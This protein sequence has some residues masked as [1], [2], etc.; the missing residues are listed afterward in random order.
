MGLGRATWAL[1]LA[2]AAHSCGA[3]AGAAQSTRTAET[4][5]VLRPPAC[6]NDTQYNSH[7]QG[8]TYLEQAPRDA[9]S[10]ESCGELCDA[11]AGCRCFTWNGPRRHCWLLSACGS[12]VAG[13]AVAGFVSGPAGC[14]PSGGAPAATAPAAGQAPPATRSSAGSWWRQQAGGSAA[15]DATG[16]PEEIAS[17][18]RLDTSRAAP[19]MR[20]VRGPHWAWGEQDGGAGGE[21][22]LTR[23]MNECAGGWWWKVKWDNGKRNIYRTGC[24]GKD[25]LRPARCSSSPRAKPRV[26]KYDDIFSPAG[27]E[28]AHNRW[29]CRNGGSVRVGRSCGF[30]RGG[31]I[32]ENATCIGPGQWSSVAPACMPSADADLPLCA[33]DDLTVPQGA[34]P[35][36][37]LP[38]CL[39]GGSVPAGGHCIFLGAGL[40][41][42]LASCGPD[43]RWAN[44]APRCRQA[45]PLPEAAGLPSCSFGELIPPA[46]AV[47]GGSEGCEPFG[48]VPHGGQ[49]RFTRSGFRCAAARCDAGR[50]FPQ[51]PLCSS[52]GCSFAALAL[53]PGVTARGGGCAGGE[54]VAPGG[55]CSLTL[56][57]GG[58]ASSRDCGYAVCSHAG[59]WQV[60]ADRCRHAAAGS[61]YSLPEQELRST[62]AAVAAA[63]AAESCLRDSDF[64]AGLAVTR[65]P[66]WG[67]G[68][69]DGGPGKVGVVIAR[70]EECPGGHWWQVM[71]TPS[72]VTN[73]YRVGCQGKTD[74]CPASSGSGGGRGAAPGRGAGGRGRR[75]GR[76]GGRGGG[77]AAVAPAALFRCELGVAHSAADSAVVRRVPS[78]ERC[79]ELC[80]ALSGCR[81][82]QWHRQGSGGVE[83]GRCKLKGAEGA[84][85]QGRYRDRDATLCVRQNAPGAAAEGGSPDGLPPQHDWPCHKSSAEA[86]AAVSALFNVSGVPTPR[87]C[88]AHCAALPDCAAAAHDPAA[89]TCLVLPAQPPAEPT[90]GPTLTV[91]VRADGANSDR[92]RPAAQYQCGRDRRFEG[93][94][95]FHFADVTDEAVCQGYCDRVPECIGVVLDGHSCA[96]KAFLTAPSE[97][98]PGLGYVACIRIGSAEAAAGGAASDFECAS[99][100]RFS[101]QPLLSAAG[102]SNQTGCNALCRGLPDCS[103]TAFS[104]GGGC[105]LLRGGGELEAPAGPFVEGEVG[106]RHSRRAAAQQAPAPAIA[107]PEDEK[108]G[109]AAEREAQPLDEAPQFASVQEES[110]YY[111]DA[112]WTQLTLPDSRE[113]WIDD[114]RGT[115]SLSRPLGAGFS[116]RRD[117]YWAGGDLFRLIDVKTV[118][119][120]EATCR[121]VP[122]CAA[123][124]HRGACPRGSQTPLAHTPD[125]AKCH[126]CDI[127]GY[128]EGDLVQDP[129]WRLSTAC[130][131][132]GESQPAPSKGADVLLCIP[133]DCS[134]PGWDAENVLGYAQRVAQ[135]VAQDTGGVA[136]APELLC[137]TAE[138]CAP[139][140]PAQGAAAEPRRGKALSLTPRQ[141]CTDG[142][143]AEV[144]VTV[145]LPN[146]TGSDGDVQEVVEGAVRDAVANT[147]GDVPVTGTG[148]EVGPSQSPDVTGDC[149]VDKQGPADDLVATQRGVRTLSECRGL[150]S[151]MPQCAALSHQ[152]DLCQLY[153]SAE[154][155]ADAAGWTTC[156]ADPSL[157]TPPK[158]NLAVSLAFYLPLSP[159]EFEAMQGLLID[160]VTD[161]L[162]ARLPPGAQPVDTGA[163]SVRANMLAGSSAAGR[164]KGHAL[165]VS[166]VQ[167][168]L[169]L[170][171]GL[172]AGLTAGSLQRA[173]S[174]AAVHLTRVYKPRRYSCSDEYAL[175]GGRLLRLLG[176]EGA[177][178]CMQH[179]T[180]TTA[181]AALLYF[182]NGTCEL[183][184]ADFRQV[185][186][187]GGAVACERDLSEPPAAPTYQC[188]DDAAYVGGDLSALGGVESE[189]TCRAL[190]SDSASD[191]DLYVYRAADSSCLLKASGEAAAVSGSPELSGRAC[192]AAR[193]SSGGYLCAAGA[194]SA[195]AELFAVG[196]IPAPAGCE[197]LCGAVPRCTGFTHR[198]A[199][200]TCT[201]QAGAGTLQPQRGAGSTGCARSGAAGQGPAAAD[202]FNCQAHWAFEGSPL[203]VVENASRADDCLRSCGGVP[204]CA[205][206]TY[207]ESRCLLYPKGAES[208]PAASAVACTRSSDPAAE[209]ERAA[210]A[211]R[212]GA[213]SFTG[214]EL[215]QI[216][217][218]ATP[219]DCRAHCGAV[220]ECIV[221]EHSAAA[222]T[223]RSSSAVRAAQPAAGATA[224]VRPDGGSPAPAA[225]AG[226]V[227]YQ[228]SENTAYQGA[229]LAEVGAVHGAEDCQRHCSLLPDCALAEYRPQS[230]DGGLCRLAAAG[231][232]SARPTAAASVLCTKHADAAAEAARFDGGDAVWACGEGD[233]GG[234]DELFLLEGV[235]SA[236]QCS[237]Q[238]EQAAAC[239]SFTFRRLQGSC[240]LRPAAAAPEAP[241]PPEATTVSCSRTA[242]GAG[243]PPCSCAETW[244][245]PRDGGQCGS[246]QRGC[247][248]QACDGS[249]Q[250]W[251]MVSEPGCAA[252]QH[253]G[254]A[255]C[256][257]GTPAAAPG[258]ASRR[259]AMPQGIAD[260]GG[261]APERHFR[262]LT[263]SFEK[264][265]GDPGGI[266]V[267]SD[268]TVAAVAPGCAAEAGGLRY[269]MLITT[270]NGESVPTAGLAAAI[271]AAAGTVVLAV[272]QEICAPEVSYF[273]F[274]HQFHIPHLTTDVFRGAAQPDLGDSEPG[275]GGLWLHTRVR[276]RLNSILAPGVAQWMAVHNAVAEELG[277]PDAGVFGERLNPVL[278][279]LGLGA[280]D[281]GSVAPLQAVAFHTRAKKA[282]LRLL[283]TFGGELPSG[284]DGGA[285]AAALATLLGVDLERVQT[286]ELRRCN[287]SGRIDSTPDRCA[288]TYRCN[289][290]S[291]VAGCLGEDGIPVEDRVDMLLRGVLLPASASPTSRRA[292]AVAADDLSGAMDNRLA[293]ADSVSDVHYSG[294]RR[295]LLQSQGGAGGHHHDPGA[296][297]EAGSRQKDTDSL[298]VGGDQGQAGDPDRDHTAD[299]TNI[300]V[301]DLTGESDRHPHD[302]ESH[303]GPALYS[304]WEG[305]VLLDVDPGLSGAARVAKL[306]EAAQTARE[307][308]QW[309]IWKMSH[310]HAVGAGFGG[311]RFELLEQADVT[312]VV[313]GC[314]DCS[315]IAPTPVSAPTPP[316]EQP[317]ADAASE[318]APGSRRLLQLQATSSSSSSSS[319]S[320]SEGASGSAAASPAASPLRR[321]ERLRAAERA[322][323]L[324]L[325]TPRRGRALN[326][327][328]EGACSLGALGDFY[329]LMSNSYNVAPHFFPQQWA[330]KLKDGAQ[331]LTGVTLQECVS[332]CSDLP[333]TVCAG[334]SRRSI[335]SNTDIQ[336]GDC[337]LKR[338]LKPFVG[339]QASFDDWSTYAVR[340]PTER[341][342]CSWAVL[343]DVALHAAEEYRSAQPLP[344]EDACKRLC[345]LVGD[346]EG[347]SFAAVTQTCYLAHEGEARAADHPGF[348]SFL[349]ASSSVAVAASG[350]QTCAGAGTACVTDG[351]STCFEAPGSYRCGCRPGF[352][353]VR[354]L[355]NVEGCTCADPLAAKVCAAVTPPP[356]VTTC[357]EQGASGVCFGGPGAGSQCVGGEADW[358]CA[359]SDGFHCVGNCDEPR[360]K[361]SCAKDSC[362]DILLGPNVAGPLR[363]L[364]SDLAAAESPSASCLQTALAAADACRPCDVFN[365]HLRDCSLTGLTVSQK[366]VVDQAASVC[367]P[368]AAVTLLGAWQQALA[369]TLH[370]LADSAGSSCS[371]AAD[372]IE[373]IDGAAA[374]AADPAR[375]WT[376]VS[377]TSVPVQ[378]RKSH[379]LSLRLRNTNIAA[380]VGE[381]DDGISADGLQQIREQL[382]DYLEVPDVTVDRLC[383]YRPDTQE[384]QGCFDDAG[385][386]VAAHSA[387]VDEAAAATAAVGGEA[388]Q[389][390]QVVVCESPPGP[391]WGAQAEGPAVGHYAVR[392][393]AGLSVRVHGAFYGRRTCH[394]NLCFGSTGANCGV[395]SSGRRKAEGAACDATAHCTCSAPGALEAVRQE[396]EGRGHCQFD[397]AAARYGDP[398]PGENKYLWVNYSC[399][400]PGAA[401]AAG[402]GR[403]RCVENGD[404]DIAVRFRLGIESVELMRIL[405]SADG[406]TMQLAPG[407]EMPVTARV[408]ERQGP[409]PS[410]GRL[411]LPA[412]NDRLAAIMEQQRASTVAEAVGAVLRERARQWVALAGAPGAEVTS[413]CHDSV[414]TTAVDC[415]GGWCRPAAAAPSV[416]TEET[417]C[418]GE[419]P[420][421][422]SYCHGHGR[423]SGFR[424][425]CACDC[426]TGYAGERCAA[427]D[428]GYSGYPLCRAHGAEA[429]PDDGAQASAHVPVSAGASVPT[430]AQ[431]DSDSRA[432][433]ADRPVA[434]VSAEVA[435]EGAAA[436]HSAHGSHDS[437]SPVGQPQTFHAA[438][439][440]SP[441]RLRARRRGLLRAL[442]QVIG[443]V[444]GVEGVRVVAACVCGQ[445]GCPARPVASWDPDQ[446]AQCEALSVADGPASEF[447]NPGISVTADTAIVEFEVAWAPGVRRP[448]AV[449]AAVAAA[450]R[451]SS[452]LAAFGITA[453]ERVGKDG[454][455]AAAAA[456]ALPAAAS[457]LAAVLSNLP[458]AAV[459]ALLVLLSVLSAA[460]G[461]CALRC[462]RRRRA[463]QREE[464]I[465]WQ[466]RGESLGIAWDGR[467]GIAAVQPGSAADRAGCGR[468]VGRCVTH[469]NGA[470]VCT[471]QDVQREARRGPKLRLTL[472]AKPA[473]PAPPA[474]ACFRLHSAPGATFSRERFLAALAEQLGRCELELEV[475]SVCGDPASHGGAV[476]TVAACGEAGELSEQLLQEVLDWELL[477]HAAGMSSVTLRRSSGMQSTRTAAPEW[478]APDRGAAVAQQQQEQAV[479]VFADNCGPPLSDCTG[480]YVLQRATI[481]DRPVWGLTPDGERLLYCADDA[482]W[483]LA[484][485][486]ANFLDRAR[487]AIAWTTHAAP[488][489]WLAAAWE[490]R[491]G[492]VQVTT[493]PGP[494]AGSVQGLPLGAR[495]VCPRDVTGGGTTAVQAGNIGVVVGAS[496]VAPQRGV[497]VRFTDPACQV[498]LLPE[499][500]EQVHGRRATPPPGARRPLRSPVAEGRVT[501][502][503]E[504]QPWCL[505]S[506]SGSRPSPLRPPLASTPAHAS[507]GGRRLSHHSRTQ[508]AHS[509][510]PS[511]AAL[512]ARTFPAGGMPQGASA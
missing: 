247:P 181:C 204:D 454:D 311:D 147:T 124:V 215:F 440:L 28:P 93:G 502:R 493:E 125:L 380:L 404:C 465:I 201:L 186:A 254:W 57:S 274:K 156:T 172:P 135:A 190:C 40:S 508:S 398:C 506:A 399:A 4:A 152:G 504:Q 246:T 52:A 7:G 433:P 235:P 452:A 278:G 245:A 146:A 269:G 390:N 44:T 418:G 233:E 1:A 183:Q 153:Q 510:S 18:C 345:E 280:L 379:T 25:D 282:K 453:A 132:Q 98:P 353:C 197:E 23:R 414:S 158:K 403:R 13:P 410:G 127:K 276:T 5:A 456:A 323:R 214:G 420:C 471:A 481:N 229:T 205:A 365:E 110:Q 39:K 128:V 145:D 483:C 406:S 48:K 157:R 131:R 102:V 177:A 442:W 160:S 199:T 478:A 206:V 495:V 331:P 459:A 32:C 432:D 302:N 107:D 361:H 392:C 343:H 347:A 244:V 242:A 50:W 349:C 263:I 358:Q 313:E 264:E 509:F 348:S 472:S 318:S 289:L 314:D 287:H 176:V 359:C 240:T 297:G 482:R 376:R 91:C 94:D 117:A 249:P 16:L 332:A 388:G 236:R 130:L 219:A 462:I 21:G 283:L 367:A 401:R 467:T 273:E 209:Q 457:A 184:S 352:E 300:T 137:C 104:P 211:F 301:R 42:D 8:N 69:Q 95:L 55:L 384:L 499:E 296:Q 121:R 427:C 305:T 11:A 458:G 424:G 337:Y 118:T 22:T 338:A 49:C 405:R 243:L 360:Q 445:A 431:S 10:P 291:I 36:G 83:G 150:C 299:S 222:C 112:N 99:G 333:A 239:R 303:S 230:S 284:D 195:P 155:I 51:R 374:A 101:G 449:V 400:D 395:F 194:F 208:V 231:Q 430:A 30:R 169:S 62:L 120:C 187:Q 63:V 408:T 344:D 97:V 198:A 370:R 77:A 441:E 255:Y 351:G 74:L 288:S 268:G 188:E 182:S 19:G 364:V 151:H 46:H 140:D 417:S 250:R 477:A 35:S 512:S 142:P 148:V 133:A 108:Q 86:A 507:G 12:P 3:V 438:T 45:P 139:H 413:A 180:N 422:S 356:T 47:A 354:C 496:S 260:Y 306:E 31:W 163:F 329:G 443:E 385:N 6:M 304:T 444:S 494:S 238:C 415:A 470:L 386:E 492:A 220:P 38:G 66:D 372:G 327:P 434:G 71:W 316:P 270:V 78:A 210:A 241:A 330:A 500:V 33:F 192:K 232:S 116:C 129:H 122:Q 321:M 54:V 480:L 279:Q 89:A 34:I 447:A 173:L 334:F 165:A 105:A 159:A 355:D 88:A 68:N 419:P 428:A 123:F 15:A 429:D 469:A 489:P 383:T 168:L 175:E 485:R 267:R 224:C 202:G 185:A 72:G 189:E 317:P 473:A 81:A 234:G 488:L 426:T 366:W 277:K 371:V 436:V 79:Q 154:G 87:D 272:E 476:V 382:S 58:A 193:Q 402:A 24:G 439:A 2:L 76:G 293:A 196:S 96:L 82:A 341:S 26:C 136:G 17:E 285:I 106:C 134:Q 503:H 307:N 312:L 393:A 450:E 265:E 294:T 162:N 498:D 396:C 295:S 310:D 357:D 170:D 490:G 85:A 286:V 53:P 309:H 29:G 315:N 171:G 228:C 271:Q 368:E 463:P 378:R 455:P 292:E 290:T 61:A 167:A 109:E 423:P 225:A 474:E 119:E 218:V 416:E 14:R 491:G 143:H 381:S 501:P 41:C 328:V 70:E 322:L 259:G 149:A 100:R 319:G 90:G 141:E 27:A 191:C 212:C 448:A 487:G 213:G 138:E 207:V 387:G 464:L 200:A 80:G 325:A 363:D 275:A 425:T 252:E 451:G 227:W 103:G 174:A 253:G 460:A 339:E 298:P 9:D 226:S 73:N 258:A 461:F 84:L 223:L 468:F 161:W 56:S 164:R 411:E 248:A 412:G 59:G 166:G 421:R 64:E 335:G 256:G 497:A 266:T 511:S 466:H 178:A 326:A 486:R 437:L 350:E 369:A 237:Q 446:R 342:V 216:T 37:R 43:G 281:S 475:A 92:A 203:L 394:N 251:C 179:C 221:A 144:I 67:W 324:A 479:W 346:C 397:A 114:T 60:S 262:T 257:D 115:V 484:D 308:L 75:F 113:L 362:S 407:D 320:G 261:S 391:V 409:E 375:E 373:V 505:D 65:G 435:P 389:T 126:T 377:L 111:A 340:C 336:P 217:D 20:V